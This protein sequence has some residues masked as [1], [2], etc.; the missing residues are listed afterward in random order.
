MPSTPTGSGAQVSVARPRSSSRALAMQ[1]ATVLACGVLPVLTL[2][3]MFAVGHGD[4]S[5]A[6]DFHHEIYPQSEVMLDG[7]SP[8]PPS[9]WDPTVAPNFIWPATVAFTHA[10]LTLLPVGIAD[11]AMVVLGLIGFA[12]SLWLVGVRDWRVYGAVALWPQVAGEMRVSHLTPLLCVLAAM[13]WRTRDRRLAP[14][15]AVGIAVAMKFFAWPLGL[16]LAARRSFAAAALAVAI[17]GASL[18]LLLPF[19][20]LDEYIRLLLRL[21]RAFDQDAYTI[22]GLIVQAGGSET[23]GRLATFAVGAALLVGTWRFRS[24]TLALAAALVLSPIV[25]LDYFAVA[26]VPLAIVRPRLSLVW[27]LPLA[28]WGMSGAGYGTG[29]AAEIARLLA[30]FTLL[31]AIVARAEWRVASAVRASVATS[32][33]LRRRDPR[34]R[35]PA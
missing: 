26:A 18:L 9:E 29:D 22:L 32:T 15:V 21:G 13:S 31:F 30:V 16:W 1:A 19:T 24:F 6:D 11:I 8:Y 17:A 12:L 33:A 14:G 7:R 34:S 3:A 27:F 20:G 25:W 2:A 28:T 10:P 5:F 4:G 35:A 23:A